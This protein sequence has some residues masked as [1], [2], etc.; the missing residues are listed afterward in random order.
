MHTI[1]WFLYFWLYLIAVLPLY[2]YLRRLEKRGERARCDAILHPTVG[3]W[4]RRLIRAAGAK[5]TVEGL[6]K[7]PSGPAVYVANHQGY[8]DI[9]VVLGYLGNDAKSLV[10]K[11]QIDRIP[12]IRRWMRLLHCVFLD[13]DNPRSA[14]ASLNEAADW[15]AQ[16]YSMVIFPEGTR[17]KTGEVAEFKG[18][19]FKIAQ[20]NKVPVV[21]FVIDGTAELMERNG[22]WIH[23]G[24][25]HLRVLDPI[26]TAG[27]TK[28]DW[29]ALPALCEER[30][31]QA[32]AALRSEHQA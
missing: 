14:V 4:A 13:R 23:G 27:Y 29:R 30:V 20:K 1:L 32:L 28:E 16:G 5:V 3:R 10:A 24:P 17:S 19:A 26:D 15:V 31:R 8:F 22:Y 6:E 9:P 12:L 25:V 7:L 18:G 2:W 21:P 11:K